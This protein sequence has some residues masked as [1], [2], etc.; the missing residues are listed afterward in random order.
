MDKINQNKLN[1][2]INKLNENKFKL[3]EIYII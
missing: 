1:R 2:Q 3:S